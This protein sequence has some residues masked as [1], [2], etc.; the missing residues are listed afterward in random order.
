MV[1]P[2]G[3]RAT[4]AALALLITLAAT[5]VAVTGQ[6]TF[7]GA[8]R[9]VAIGDVH[10]A[11]DRLL[12]LLRA[13]GVADAK[14]RWTGGTTHL[15]QL[16][17]VVDRGTGDT[18]LPRAADEAR[19]G[20]GEGGWP[21]PRASRQP[22]GDEH[23][24]RP[25]L[26]EPARVRQVPHAAVRAAP[27][28]PLRAAAAG[29]PRGGEGARREVRRVGLPGAVRGADTTRLRRAHTGVL[30]RGPLRPLAAC[31][32]GAGRRQRRRLRSPGG[33]APETAALG[34]DGIGCAAFTASWGRTSRKTRENPTT[35]LAARATAG[36]C[37]TAG[38]RARRRRPMRLRWSAPCSRS[39][40]GRWSS[41]T[42]SRRAGAS[43]PGSAAGW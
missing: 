21:A 17:D 10:G 23:R 39:A 41:G 32:A 9:V 3:R 26:R 15:V 16:G 24:R 43:R 25:A 2:R 36:L 1:S 34:C 42:P 5:G 18:A 37:G 27:A 22:R 12:E 13:A 8:S 19:A 14:G 20:G 6:C 30:R 38:W 11:Y 29:R 35:T 7:D 28:Q 4:A 31:A 40:R 33:V